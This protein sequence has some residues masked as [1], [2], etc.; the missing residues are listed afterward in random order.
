MLLF[1]SIYLTF[2]VLF[3]PF[4]PEVQH[5]KGCMG[6]AQRVSTSRVTNVIMLVLMHRRTTISV[7]QDQVGIKMING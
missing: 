7:Y 4:K 6:S 3:T 2:I 1:L 5:R